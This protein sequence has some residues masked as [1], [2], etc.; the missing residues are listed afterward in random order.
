MKYSLESLKCSLVLIRTSWRNGHEETGRF[1]TVLKHPFPHCISLG[2][3][4]IRCSRRLYAYTLRY[5]R[6]QCAYSDE[7]P[8]HNRRGGLCHF[9]INKV[10]F[11]LLNVRDN[12]QKCITGLTSVNLYILLPDLWAAK[13]RRNIWSIPKITPLLLKK[14]MHGRHAD[15]DSVTAPHSE[16]KQT[17]HAGNLC[18]WKA[19]GKEASNT[20]T[21]NLAS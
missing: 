5:N 2:E 16:G 3:A 4:Y 17:C 8:L 15:Q 1:S 11:P 21:G 12:L 20:V 14:T 9:D 10:T 6:T 7:N 19:N 18:S 13:H